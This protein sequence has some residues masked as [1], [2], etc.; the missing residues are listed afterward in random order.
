ML[1]A[2]S[3]VGFATSKVIARAAEHFHVI[4]TGR[5]LDKVTDAMEEI[6]RA[7]GIKGSLSA[8]KLDVTDEASIAQAAG[9]VGEKYGRLDVLVNN[10]GVG[11][12]RL[13]LQPRFRACLDTNVIGPAM[14]A[15]AFRPLLLKSARPY[16]I[17]VSSGAG[18]LMRA[19][20]SVRQFPDEDAYRVSK[21]ALNMIGVLEARDYG[22]QGLKVF[23]MS[24]GFVVSNLRGTGEAERSGWGKA[25]DPEVSGKTVLSIIQGERDAD[26]GK[27]VHDTGLHPW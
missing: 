21:A 13:E 8:V 20:Q 2:N 26:V 23:I 3:G 14:V 9:L 16:S 10:A 5:S 19:S 24:P 25:G 22:P 12:L 1:G 11:G 4:M 17:Y 6:K 15:A 27:L 18:S 7:E